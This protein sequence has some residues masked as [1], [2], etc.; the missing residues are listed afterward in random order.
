METLFAGE[1]IPYQDRSSEPQVSFRK[2]SYHSYATKWLSKLMGFDYEI[3]YKSGKSNVAADALS[4]MKDE[5]QLEAD[6]QRTLAT[7]TVVLCQWVKEFQASCIQDPE[8]QRLIQDL[9]HDPASHPSFSWQ[10]QM[11]YYKSRL[12]VGHD[13]QFRLKLIHEHHASPVGGHSGGERT[14]QRLKQA[15]FW[16]GMNRLCYT[17]WLAVMFAR[18]TR[19]RRW[20]LLVYFNHY[21]FLTD[22]GMTS[23]WILSNVCPALVTKL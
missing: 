23:L 3:V 7:M 4:R 12:V 13:D 14:Y 11:L 2:A 19:M 22:C 15:F 18:D 9:Q 1:K 5:Y 8:L 17:M 20:P 21:L 6:S 10:H 16:E